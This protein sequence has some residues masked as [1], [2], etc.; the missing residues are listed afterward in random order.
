MRYVYMYV[1]QVPGVLHGVARV[2]DD[3]GPLVG[4]GDQED[5][6]VQPEIPYAF[7]VSVWDGGGK[8]AGFPEGRSQLLYE[9]ASVTAKDWSTAFH[10]V[11]L[12]ARGA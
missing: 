7:R 9:L 4:V 1:L 2:D 11:A 10:R 3:L 6:L 12:S 5:L 8:E